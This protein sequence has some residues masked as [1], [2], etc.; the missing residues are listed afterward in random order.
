MQ[1]NSCRSRNNG[2]GDNIVGLQEN[3][4]KAHRETVIQQLKNSNNKEADTFIQSNT[5]NQ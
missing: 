3:K 2:T 4:H 1:S 5:E